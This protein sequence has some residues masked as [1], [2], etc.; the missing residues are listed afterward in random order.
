MVGAVVARPDAERAERRGRSAGHP[1]PAVANSVGVVGRM[2]FSRRASGGGCGGL[3]ADRPYERACIT[4][5]SGAFASA[6]PCHA[7]HT[8]LVRHG[9]AGSA[10]LSSYACP[11]AAERTRDAAPHPQMPAVIPRTPRHRPGGNRHCRHV[12]WLSD[13]GGHKRVPSRRARTPGGTAPRTPSAARPR[14]PYS[15]AATVARIT[16]VATSAV[17]SNTVASPSPVICHTITAVPI[18]APMYTGARLNDSRVAVS[19]ETSTSS[20]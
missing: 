18:S 19:S 20:G 16:N 1:C 9:L 5:Q 8:C 3:L 7:C 10:P 15:K 11:R 6:V 4:R 12:R 13:P 14:N 2:G 17:P